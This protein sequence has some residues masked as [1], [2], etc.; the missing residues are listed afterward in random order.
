ML[1]SLY[2]TVGEPFAG[3]SL[4][5]V[6]GVAVIYFICFL[7]RG[8][9]GFGALAP[10]VTFTSWLLPAHH[11]VLLAVIAATIPQLQLLPES[12]RGADW[13]VARPVL[14]AVI[15]TTAVG[16]WI[17]AHMSGDWLTFILGFVISS[18]VLLDVLKLLDRA[19]RHIDIRAPA[20]AFGLAALSGIING[21]AGAGGMVVLVVYLKH[22]CRDHIS[23]RH[24]TIFLGTIIMCWRF[25]LTF[26]TDMVTI[27]LL[28]E[29][30][31]MLPVIYAGV[32]L[33]TRF[34]RDISAKRYHAMLQAVLLLSA[35]GLVAD[36]LLRV[37]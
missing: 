25:V 33:G 27:K 32:W 26:L 34:T 23:L 15:V 35:L 31:L 22:A 37:L 6:A 7:A 19:V 24:T 18:A 3:V 2:L 20:V 4:W 9:I 14:A 1:S 13:H 16:A 5:A 28:V 17:F 21:I 10:A 29:A 36:G 11:A 12:M 8:A 30:A